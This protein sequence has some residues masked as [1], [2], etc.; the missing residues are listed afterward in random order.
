MTSG[1]ALPSIL[2]HKRPSVAE[3]SNQ[4]TIKAALKR[5][6]GYRKNLQI[7]PGDFERDMANGNI[8][9]APLTVDAANAQK[10]NVKIFD[11]KFI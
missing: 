1:E 11:K 5:H 3:Q 8:P 2:T 9:N 10:K 7:N 6:Q 4:A